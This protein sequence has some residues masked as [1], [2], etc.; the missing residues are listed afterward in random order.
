LGPADIV[1]VDPTLNAGV[2]KS[3]GQY[4]KGL[5]G[6]I[7]TNPNIIMGSNDDPGTR[8]VILALAGR[9]PVRVTTENGVIEPGDFITSSSEPGLGMKATKA[10]PIVGR[11]LTGWDGDDGLPQHNAGVV[12]LFVQNGYYNGESLTPPEDFDPDKE[13]SKVVLGTLIREKAS[14]TNSVIAT[15]E[16]N[17]D[18]VT[19]GLEVITPRVLADVLEVNTIRASLENDIY[20]GLGQS[21]SLVIGPSGNSTSTNGTAS[22]TGI[23]F[24]Y[25]GNGIFGGSVR[26]QDVLLGDESVSSTLANIRSIFGEYWTDLSTTTATS[27][28]LLT[29]NINELAS[30]TSSIEAS[31]GDIRNRVSVLEGLNLNTLFASST[32]GIVIDSM[33]SL[34]GGLKINQLSS[35]SDYLMLM[36]DTEF[37]GRPY[38][39]VDTAGFAVIGAG[40]RSVD[41]V[42]ERDYLET[43]IIN[44]TMSANEVDIDSLFAGGVSYA[45]TNRSVS[46]FS[47][48][49]NKDAPVDIMFNWTAFA[50]KS[51]KTFTSTSTNPVIIEEETPTPIVEE[52]PQV[53]DPPVELPPVEN[54]PLLDETIFSETLPPPTVEGQGSTTSELVTP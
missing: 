27:T 33:V 23:V 20:I 1:S 28:S 53:I 21:G 36:S 10:G 14:S 40:A 24:D 34:N 35:I 31:M 9:V 22:S 12:M 13:F 47:I 50:V 5:M 39:T 2:R 43:P 45:L 11:A 25:L 32:Q 15:S 4:D 6:V 17:V 44:T 48:K 16:I 46:G 7:S 42:F 51:P 8:T 30:T 52:S 54:V 18:R 29:Q 38:F 3:T 19:S 37:I 41:V 26:A 49:I